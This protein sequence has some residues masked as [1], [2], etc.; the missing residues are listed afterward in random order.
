L[1]AL[2]YERHLQ[3]PRHGIL[4][5]DFVS[6]LKPQDIEGPDVAA[7]QDSEWQNF[8]HDI[9]DAESLFEVVAEFRELSNTKVFKCKHIKEYLNFLNEKCEQLKS[10]S[11][12]QVGNVD[13][14]KYRVEVCIIAFARTVDYLGFFGIHGMYKTDISRAE[15]QQLM[16]RIH[17]LNM[18]HT[19]MAVDY[20]ELELSNH[21]ERAIMQDIV[22]LAIVE[23]GQNCMNETYNDMDFPIPSTWSKE[24]PRKGLFTCFYCR[25]QDTINNICSKAN[26]RHPGAVPS[27]A[28]I[29][30]FTDWVH[31]AKCHQIKQKMADKFPNAK[32]CFKAIDKDGGGSVD[33]KEM[34][35][36]LFKVLVPSTLLM[37][38][39]VAADMPEGSV[40]LF[41][42]RS[43]HF[44]SCSYP[45]PCMNM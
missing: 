4:E 37:M 20:Y 21:P 25:E 28:Q 41:R 27:D 31:K 8:L 30:A 35:G 1:Q 42:I 23:P 13:L 14:M 36:G 38:C 44:I 24:V 22:H 6:L 43:S 9:R 2:R 32:A 40:H 26:K 18:F 11:S 39:F 33:R 3:L 19:D 15:R 29:P 5:L 10:K 7:I 12:T 16:E 17:M 34:A 45:T